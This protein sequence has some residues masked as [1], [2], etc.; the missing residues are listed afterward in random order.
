MHIFRDAKK[1]AKRLLELDCNN[2]I[3]TLGAAGVCFTSKEDPKVVYVKAPKVDKVVD[4][5]GSGDAFVGGN[6]FLLNI[7]VTLL[8]QIFSAL[9]HFIAN[10]NSSSMLQN[11]GAACEIAS[12]SVQFNGTQS[13][14]DSFPKI[15]P[16]NKIYA[17]EIL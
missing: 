11:I 17:F 9:A 7:I 15:D 13:S 5:T 8:N 3:I 14:Y 6:S 4:T 10:H 12:H 16:S 1:A 2:V